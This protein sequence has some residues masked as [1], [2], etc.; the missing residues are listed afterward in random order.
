MNTENNLHIPDVQGSPDKR[1]LPITRVGVRDIQLPIK[2]NDGRA[3]QH[4]VAMAEMTVHLPHDKKGTHMSRFIEIL[5][6]M[7]EFSLD[8]LGEIHS[9]MLSRLSAEEGTINLAFPYF[10]E[11]SAPVSG[12]KSVMNY[13][14]RISSD[15]R[16]DDYGVYAEITVPVTSLCP[17]S[18]E[19]SEYGAHNQRSHIII[20]IL[21]DRNNPITLAE[22]AAI[23]ENGGSCPI[24][25]TLKR[26]DEKFVTERAYENPKFV[27]DIVRDVAIAL[28]ADERISW[29]SVSSENFESIHNHSAYAIIECDKRL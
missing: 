7:A 9:T 23:G 19:I 26:P 3:V 8:N 16:A 12:M 25:A 14:V 28:N 21:Y 22:L 4:T 20:S 5:N 24:W 27:E 1:E 18:K 13:E 29:Y 6:E 15:G 11:K 17:C 10:L 2:F